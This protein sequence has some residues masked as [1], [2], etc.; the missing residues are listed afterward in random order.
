MNLGAMMKQ[1]QEMQAKIAEIQ[2]RLEKLEIEG[3]AG[4]GMVKVRLNGKGLMRGLSID[5]ALFVDED[6]AVLEDLIMAAHNDAKRRVEEE[7]SRQMASLTEGLA[8]PPG[9]KMPF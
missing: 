6:K 3:S 5:P 8:L 7:S 1:A 4:A 2:A 9:F